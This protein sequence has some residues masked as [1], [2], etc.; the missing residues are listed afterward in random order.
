[1][2]KRLEVRKDAI[3]R[4]HRVAVLANPDNAAM[5]QYFQAMEIAAKEL[6]VALFRFDARGAAGLDG[7]FAAMAKESVDALTVP[8]DVAFIAIFRRIGELAV[9]QRL[10][11]ISFIEYADSGGLFG[12]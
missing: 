9:K 7:A 5:G 4:V 8:E 10:P 2:A 6:N 1:M 3:P 12:Y 11:S